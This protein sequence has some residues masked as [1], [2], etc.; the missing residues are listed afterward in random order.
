MSASTPRRHD[1]VT[2]TYPVGVATAGDDM[3]ADTSPRSRP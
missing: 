2:M 1:G 3:I